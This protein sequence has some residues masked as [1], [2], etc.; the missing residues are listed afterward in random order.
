MLTVLKVSSLASKCVCYRP[1][2]KQR[3][4][5]TQ[6]NFKGLGIQNRNMPAESIQIVD[7]KNRVICV[8]IILSPR[9]LIIK[10]SIFSAG[11]GNKSVTVWAKYLGAPEGPY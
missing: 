5:P 3:G 1:E 11:N 8:V 10:M 9:V 6:L 4:T 2:N 7:E